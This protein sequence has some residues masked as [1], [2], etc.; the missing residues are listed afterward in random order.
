M[1]SL[2]ALLSLMTVALGACTVPAQTN[3]TNAAAPA[4]NFD[5]VTISGSSTANDVVLKVNAD[6]GAASYYCCNHFNFNAISDPSPPPPGRYSLKAWDVISGDGTVTWVA[7][8]FDANTGHT[9]VLTHQRE[10]QY[11]WQAITN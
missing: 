11:Q 9:W 5:A 3:A 8:R 7:Y 6:T 4:G 1:K 2:F 10:G